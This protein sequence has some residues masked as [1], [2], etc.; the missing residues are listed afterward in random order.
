MLPLLLLVLLRLLLLLPMSGVVC[1][2]IVMVMTLAVMEAT[3]III[4]VVLVI[5][6]WSRVKGT[7][8][9]FFFHVVVVHGND[10]PRCDHHYVLP[11]CMKNRK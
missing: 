2:M 7:Q 4:D 9:G 8:K 3:D 5:K 11:V 1:E 10:M 6:A